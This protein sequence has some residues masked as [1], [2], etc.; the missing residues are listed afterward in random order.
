[1]FV[2]LLMRAHL[3]LLFI[4]PPLVVLLCKTLAFFFPL[5]VFAMGFIMLYML[6]CTLYG[7]SHVGV[8]ILCIRTH[9]LRPGRTSTQGVLFMIVNVVFVMLACTAQLLWIVPQYATFGAQTY[10]DVRTNVVTT[11][12]MMGAVGVDHFAKQLKGVTPNLAP[13][14]G[15]PS[16]GVQVM[17]NVGTVPS[18]GGGRGGGGPSLLLELRTAPRRRIRPDRTKG[19]AEGGGA[20]E[21][22]S[23]T[24]G[25]LGATEKKGIDGKSGDSVDKKQKEKG[26]KEKKKEEGEEEKKK[27]EEQKKEEQ[28][29]EKVAAPSSKAEQP[30]LPS[31]SKSKPKSKAEVAPSKEAA[32][33]TTSGK[34]SS[35]S[36]TISDKEDEEVDD[37]L[38]ELE[39]YMDILESGNYTNGTVVGDCNPTELSTMFNNVAVNYPF[40]GALLQYM[41][42]IYV[43]MTAM[44]F[45]IAV[46]RGKLT[47]YCIDFEEDGLIMTDSEGDDNDDEEQDELLWSEE[48]D[49]EFFED[50]IDDGNVNG[51][52][53]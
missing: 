15:G 20:I 42:I 28:K 33:A 16:E 3:Y 9:S 47:T 53:K 49:D 48:R 7:M 27:K 21:E 26:E 25:A 23:S 14:N 2:C 46:C 10:V 19:N 40:L 18:G 12:T 29:K 6:A 50:D 31:S 30:A 13:D 41:T 37:G 38:S 32:S 43:M 44:Y 4:S 51:R 36:G 11:C 39:A 52:K 34:Q 45:Y 24:D 17:G 8:R 35:G 1:M 22:G 5:D